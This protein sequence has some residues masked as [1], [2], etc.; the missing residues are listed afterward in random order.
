MNKFFTAVLISTWL[1]LSFQ[2]TAQDIPDPETFFGHRMG[3]EGKIISYLDGFRYYQILAGKS[4]RIKVEEIGKTTMGNPFVLVTISSPENMSGLEDIRK[5]RDLL[6]DPEKT[7]EKEARELA[8]DLPAVVFHT[9]SIHSTEIST[10]QVVPE[11]VY[12][13]VTG[14]DDETLRILKNT[15]ILIS[16]SAN[17]DGQIMLKKWYDEN[18]GKSWEGRMP[19]LYHSYI[20]HD[21]NR[22][23]IMLHFPEQ[24]LT[25]QKIFLKWHPVY[26]IEMHQ[27]GRN[28]ARIFVPPYQEPYDINTPSE[29]METMSLVGMAMSHRLTVEGK[30]GAVKDAIFDLYTPARAFQVY[31]G[32]G[33]ILTETA[34]ANFAR[35]INIPYKD[36]Q[37]RSGAGT[38]D[39]HR[40][41]WN[42]ST[43]WPGGDWT[44]R[45]M[46][47]YQLTTNKAALSVVASDPAEFNLGMYHA[48]KRNIVAK[49]WPYAYV[50]PVIQQDPSSLGRLLRTLQRGEITIEQAK[51]PFEAGGRTFEKDSYVIRLHQRY[52]A[53]AK[54]LLETQ[55]YPDL[56]RSPDEDPITP[57]D[58]TANTLPLMMG[59]DA[60]MIDHPFNA[61]L[62]VVKEP[63][64]FKGLVEGNGEGGFAILPGSNEAFSAVSDLLD[65]GFIVHRSPSVLPSPRGKLPPGTFIVEAHPGL[66]GI[67]LKLRD[68]WYF[69]AIGLTDQP[70]IPVKSLAKLHRPRIGIYEPWGGL[71]DAGWTRFMLEQFGMEPVT[72]RNADI[73]EGKLNEK[74]DILI[75]PEGLSRG[76][77]LNGTSSFPDK[78]KGGIGEKGVRELKE[79]VHNGGTISAFGRTSM[80]IT[81]L[82]DIPLADFSAS[83]SRKE[84]YAPGSLVLTKLDPRSPLTY[85][86]PGKIAVLNRRGPL[87]VA[88]ATTG[89]SPRMAGMYPDYD[90]RMSGFLLG[91]EKME[92]KGSLA[93]QDFGK[94]RVVLFSMAPEFRAMTHA[95]YKLIFNAIYW[96][97][98]E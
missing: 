88:K 43:P 48:L 11:L 45:E 60:V 68:K 27:M 21:N 47:E 57:Y 64:T 1:L 20:G 19:W 89:K 17:P 39:P 80:T 50:L 84:Y 95:G 41:S 36:L 93:V 44:F 25:A 55:D 51:K 34:S 54:T 71:I 83:L 4:D 87:F 49:S 65:K 77:I 14:N 72:V 79:F 16:P 85:G 31:R 78:Y 29:V 18:I 92:D 9:S 63:V 15:V 70:K 37:G 75:F 40:K 3:A 69:H 30:A 73:L 82:L 59:V 12:D 58:V 66:R 33:R 5:Q 86:M 28:G 35:K 23:W 42:Y 76:R 46:V 13:L 53:W 98:E 26:S 52:G 61:N 96:A 91:P 81:G 56:R 32:T 38:Y 24:R 7:G 62:T 22:D 10:A 97:A 67:L 94:G 8:Q 2:V 90:P 74:F 6:C